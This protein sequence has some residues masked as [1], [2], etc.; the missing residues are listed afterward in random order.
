MPFYS[1]HCATC[2]A[3]VELLIGISDA[4][5]PTLR[6]QET[7]AADVAHG[8]PGQAPGHHESGTIAGRARRTSQQFQSRRAAALRL[9]GLLQSPRKHG[10]AGALS[11]R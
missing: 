1:Y 10:A 3:D 2:A 9:S 4:G 7:T 8:A 6:W 11:P 5:L